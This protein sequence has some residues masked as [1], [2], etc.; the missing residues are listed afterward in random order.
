MTRLLVT[1]ATG[2]LGINLSLLATELGHH[3]TGL[4][5]SRRLQTTTFDLRQVDLVDRDSAMRVIEKAKPEAIIHCA[6]IADINLAEKNPELTRKLNVEV[7]GFLAKVTSNWD[8]PLIHI[9][10]DAVFDGEKG[11]YIESD[12][13]NPLSLYAKSKLDAESIVQ[14]KNPEALVARVVFFGWSLSGKRSLSEFFFNH[15]QSGQIVQG[16]SDTFFSP[17]YVE[18]LAEILFEMLRLGLSGIYH[19][20]SSQSM[21]KFEFGVQI[22][23]RFGFNPSLVKPV[24]ASGLDRGA[25]RSLNLSLRSDKVQEALGH[26]LPSVDDGIDRLFQ[27]WREGY[28]YYLQN[29]VASS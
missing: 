11:G 18:D 6:A 1:G 21:S 19:V 16:Y 10:S 25:K 5:H 12:P 9:S 29:L 4:A 2:L 28:P 23:Q 24:Q 17:L 20:T 15:L 14:E 13:P 3:V 22:A 26:P 27:R 7:P 8:I